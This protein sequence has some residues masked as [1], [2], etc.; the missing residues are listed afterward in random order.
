MSVVQHTAT[1]RSRCDVS[2]DVVVLMIPVCV[3]CSYHRDVIKQFQYPATYLY[4]VG[5]WFLVTLGA[6]YFFLAFALYVRSLVFAFLLY[7]YLRKGYLQKQ[8]Q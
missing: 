1:Y 7:A 2:I 3:L 6:N 5:G 8:K 4:N